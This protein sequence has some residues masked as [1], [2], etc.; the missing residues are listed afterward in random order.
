MALR[1]IVVAL[2]VLGVMA[3]GVA[4][5]PSGS[6]AD[7]VTGTNSSG[8]PHPVAPESDTAVENRTFV[9]AD[10]ETNESLLEVPVADGDELTLAY[11]HSVEKTPVEDVYVVDET[12][13]Y[14]DRTVFSSYGAGLPSE[15]S[16]DWTEEGF[17]VSV[18]ES[19]ER[20]HVAPGS[21]AG[22]VLRVRDRCYDLVDLSGGASVTL[23]VEDRPLET[24]SESTGDR[25]VPPG[26]CGECS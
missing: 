21:I 10:T 25:A 15:A 11:V 6:V 8:T 26:T 22:H 3:T 4:S 20:I 1:S 12:D 13:L 23:F 19:F 2:V 18:D 7:G 24:A 16:V 5:I 14:M 17:V 9:V